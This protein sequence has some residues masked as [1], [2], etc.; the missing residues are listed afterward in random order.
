MVTAL[1]GMLAE[2]AVHPGT[3]RVSGVIDLPVAREAATDYPVVVGSSMKGALRDKAESLQLPDVAEAFG[4]PDRAGGL[5]VS[6]ARLLLLPVRSLA[7]AYR[8]LTCP[9]LLERFRR[10]TARA[11]LNSRFSLPQIRALKRRET[12]AAGQGTLFLE[13]RRFQVADPIPDGLSK[14]FGALLLHEETKNRL[15]EML[16]VVHDEDFSWFARYA[17]AVQAR[18]ML[19]DNSK[20]SKNLWYEEKLVA[21]TVMYATIAGREASSLKILKKLFPVADPYLQ[22][23]GNETIG[24]GWFAVTVH[25][26]KAQETP[27]E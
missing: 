15:G 13:E 6:D 5:L 10:D 3:G 8:W 17:L 21:D 26:S 2:T 9:H 16:A 14:T 11:G 27:D 1:L 25:R 18:N 7:G 23:G 4:A 20:T 24:E 22:V 12:L 19:D